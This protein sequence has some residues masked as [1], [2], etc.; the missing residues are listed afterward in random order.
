M[1]LRALIAE[2][3]PILAATL[4]AALQRLW[5]EL[6]LAASCTDGE[7][8]VGQALALRPDI[9]FLDIKM[10]GKTGLEVVEELAERWDG[11]QPFPQVVFVTAYDDYAVDAFERAAADYVR[12]PVND[13][14]LGV[15]VE[16]LRQRCAARQPGGDMARLLAQMQ[17][18]LPAA[19][20]GAHLTLIRAAV[21][22]QVRMIPVAEVA[23]FQAV[24]KYVNVVTREGEALIRLSLRELLRQLDGN[25]FCQVN[26]AAI[27]NL[28]H[29]ASVTRDEFGKLTLNFRTRPEKPRISPLYAHLFR[30]M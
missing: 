23:F 9:L 24:D 8:A 26:R 21:G 17:A 27:V 14:R 12:K 13:Q 25:Q 30:Q 3:E 22:N 18:L 10:P 29:V 5:P 11:P 6:E 28:A 20:E 15:T 7:A 1:T 16:R 19:P 2:D 4:A